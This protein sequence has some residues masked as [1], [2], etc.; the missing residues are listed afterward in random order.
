VFV[1]KLFNEPTAILVPGQRMSGAIPPL[2][3]R[4][5]GMVLSFVKLELNGFF[6]LTLSFFDS[7]THAHLSFKVCIL[8]CL[9]AFC[10][11][12]LSWVNSRGPFEKF[13]DWRQCAA[14][15]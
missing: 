8:I 13:V 7:S 11:V 10:F 1:L 15:M 6:G 14:I 2:P 5:H 12:A 9:L 3:I 4:L